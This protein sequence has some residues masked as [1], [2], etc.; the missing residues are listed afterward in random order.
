MLPRFAHSKAELVCAGVLPIDQLTE[1][2]SAVGVVCARISK[3]DLEQE[4]N[5]DIR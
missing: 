1:V 4:Y 5:I 3:D 2:L